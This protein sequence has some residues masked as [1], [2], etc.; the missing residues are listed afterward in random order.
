M[1]FGV[2]VDVPGYGTVPEVGIV[3]AIVG[4]LAWLGGARFTTMGVITGFNTL[5]D[6]FQ[7]PVH[8][9]EL[10]GWMLLSIIAVGIF[11]SRVE[12]RRTPLH[13]VNGQRMFAGMSVLISWIIISGLDWFTTYLGLSEINAGSWDIQRQLAASPLILF[14][15]SGLLTFIPEVF[16]ISGLHFIGLGRRKR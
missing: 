12:V 7:A 4:S 8:I 5:A 11:F 9:P 14:T 3:L 6:W 13:T 1:L 16:V 2:A 15:V 10:H